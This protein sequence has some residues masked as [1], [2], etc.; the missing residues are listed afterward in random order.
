MLVG[1]IVALILREAQDIL[2]R[3]VIPVN[4]YQPTQ[5]ICEH[6]YNEE[7]KLLFRSRPSA[8]FFYSGYLINVHVC[9]IIVLFGELENDRKWYEEEGLCHGLF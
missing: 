5:N 3:R 7:K 1:F 6:L 9:R 2:N 4:V 8:E